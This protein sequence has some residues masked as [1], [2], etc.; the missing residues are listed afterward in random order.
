MSQ[1]G[2][3]KPAMGAA[4]GGPLCA[5]QGGDSNMQGLPVR[6]AMPFLWQEMLV[7]SLQNPKEG[8]CIALWLLGVEEPFQNK[9]KSF[10]KRG[11]P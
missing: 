10:K 1:F 3:G 6:H 4:E 8:G 9:Q 2:P 7:A 11:H 5:F